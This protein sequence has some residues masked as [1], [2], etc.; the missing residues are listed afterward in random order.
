MKKSKPKQTRL[1]CPVCGEFYGSEDRGGFIEVGTGRRFCP[2]CC[3]D[4]LAT[5]HIKEDE[6]MPGSEDE[7]ADTLPMDQ[8]IPEE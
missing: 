3:S 7:H 2:A 6:F 4:I 8:F 5:S 1:R